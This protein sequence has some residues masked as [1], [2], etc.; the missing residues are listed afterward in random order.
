MTDWLNAKSNAK[1]FIMLV[2]LTIK[3]TRASKVEKNQR[4][5]RKVCL[6]ISRRSC[7]GLV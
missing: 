6:A 1:D 2:T 4:A 3:A 5:E 7:Q